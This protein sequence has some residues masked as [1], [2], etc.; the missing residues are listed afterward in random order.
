MAEPENQPTAER[1]KTMEKPTD[2]TNTEGGSGIDYADW[3]GACA[4]EVKAG[5]RYWED[6]AVNGQD[7]VNGDQIPMREGNYWEPWIDLF[8]GMIIGWPFGKTASIHY[9][10]CDDGEYWLTD[11]TCK[12]LRKWK[13]D[14]VP[15]ALLCWGDRGYG[16]YIIFD[17]DENG[18]IEG[19]EK[20]T[21][22]ADEWEVLPND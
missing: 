17:V 15:D 11:E 21:L 22:N 7:D 13:G 3:L 14:Y 2:T 9:K 19:W 20:P 16:D 8:H 18:M 4:L 12:K 5:V 1:A 6:A 10:V